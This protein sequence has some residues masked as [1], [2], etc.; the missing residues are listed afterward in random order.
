[1]NPKDHFGILDFAQC[2]AGALE[3]HRLTFFVEHYVNNY[4]TDT[5]NS[6]M[7]PGY[8]EFNPPSWPSKC[9]PNKGDW[10]LTGL[11]MCGVGDSYP[12]GKRP[13]SPT[14]GVHFDAE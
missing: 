4:Y 9:A 11:N 12:E 2:S 8:E 5:G 7:H 13:P 1:M 6:C 3:E 14:G 10:I